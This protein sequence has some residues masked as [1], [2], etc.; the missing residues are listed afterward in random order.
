MSIDLQKIDCNCNNCKYQVR[1]LNKFKEAA[2]LHK[3]WQLDYFNMLKQN[4]LNKAKEY[5]D[6]TKS[7]YDPEKA[8]VLKKEAA[9]MKFQHNK[10]ESKINFGFCS[11]LKKDISWIPNV[12][13][14]E[15]QECF[16]HRKD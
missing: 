6:K 3:Q 9:K 10:K 1:D 11:K 5:L 14:L 13:Q 7:K 15:T 16:K 4:I 8:S 12:C 2:E